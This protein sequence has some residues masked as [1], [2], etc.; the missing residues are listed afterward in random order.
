MY[1]VILILNQRLALIVLLVLF[2]I[3]N[4][5][6]QS[7]TGSLTKQQRWQLLDYNKDT[8]YGASVNRAYSE[9]LAG[10][11]SHPVIVAVID[12]GVDIDHPDLREHIWTN[13]KEIPANGIDEDRNGYIDDV[14]GWNFLGGKDGRVIYATNSEADREYARLLPEFAGKDS[15]TAA[16]QKDYA[17]FRKVKKEHATDSI[18]RNRH[19]YLMMARMKKSGNE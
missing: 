18:S 17:Y 6:A 13:K 7:N 14:H 1:Q 9:I 16:H 4:C 8:V 11:K 12:E 5:F 19:S 2:A 15:A 3:I 10:K